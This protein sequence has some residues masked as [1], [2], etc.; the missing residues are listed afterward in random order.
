MENGHSREGWLTLAEAASR[1]GVSVYT[2]RRQVKRGELEAEQVATPHGLAWRVRLSNL[3]GDM[4]TL[5][6]EAEQVAQGS[7]MVELI[8]LIDQYRAAEE[9][10]RQELMELSGR[11]GYFQAQL[12]QA[13]ETIRALEAPRSADVDP[14]ATSGAE[15][16]PDA[17]KRPRW[18]RWLGL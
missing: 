11:V 7:T 14:D 6:N 9:R 8:R 16:A 18:R 10:H 4:V 2:V 17:S 1:L 12:E 13:R 5:T 3:P 15:A